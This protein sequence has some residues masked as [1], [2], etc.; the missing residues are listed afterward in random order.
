M[1]K[2][3]SK[4]G[5]IITLVAFIVLTIVSIFLSP[6]V[7]INYDMRKYLPSDSETREALAVLDKEFGSSS[8]IQVM[9]DNLSIAQG[10]AIANEIGNI[11][12]VKSVI[13]L[14]TVTD[15]RVPVESMDQNLIK[16]YYKDGHLLFTVEFNDDDYS[17][18]VGDGINQITNIMLNHGIEVSLRG[19]AIETKTSRDYVSSEMILIL[20]VAVPLAIIILFL[21]S[22][23]WIEPVVI[24]INLGIAIVINLG[25]NFLLRDVSYITMS[26]A[27]ILQLAMSLDYSLFIVHRYY[28]E[29]DNG[30]SSYEAAV[31]SAKDAFG[32]VT[33]SAATTI[34]GFLALFIMQYQIGFDIGMSLVKAIVISYIVTILLFPVL[35]IYFDK[36]LLKYRHKMILPKFRRMTERLFKGRFAIV[37]G[38]I[39]IGSLAFFLQGKTKYQYGDSAV[40]DKNATAYIHQQKITEQFGVF[41]PVVILYEI[42]DKEN[43]LELVNQLKMIPEIINI[44]SILTSVAPQIPEEMLPP[45]ALAQFKSQNYYRMII[46]LNSNKETERTYELSEQIVDLTNQTLSKKGYILGVPVATTEIK[47]SVTSDGILVQ[48]VS[49]IAI[50]LVIG[51]ILKNPITPLILVLL[52]EVSIFINIAITFI[53]GGT[54]AYIGYLVVSSL[55]LGATIDYAV[56]LS[57]RYQEFRKTLPKKEA[58]IEA[59]TRST[60][61]IITSAVVLATAGFVVAF[62]SKLGVVREIGLLIGRGALLSGVLVLFILPALLLTFD[63]IIEAT[64]I[65]I[66][67]KKNKKEEITHEENNQ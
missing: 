7:K 23:S 56:L 53:T 35:L 47:K 63:K 1:K 66:N 9:T 62:I 55:Q 22:S 59:Q 60:P 65:K 21:A 18:K 12:I 46:Y 19:P 15:I 31:L 3:L 48:L 40:G 36:P 61:A 43:A 54:L 8:M 39:I 13:W 14:G 52:I 58:M 27:S 49:A 67:F 10:E 51:V 32:T 25:A 57:S 16:D 34:F 64:N 17:L 11:E 30:L 50:A 37:V 44:Q 29:R 26:I 2:I 33:A 20:A 45:E 38:F 4:K 5:R 28:E 42:E 41:Q 6:L 24:L